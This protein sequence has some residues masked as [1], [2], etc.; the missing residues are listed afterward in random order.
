MYPEHEHII[1]EVLWAMAERLNIRLPTRFYESPDGEEMGKIIADEI[2]A[3]NNDWE[4]VYSL[5]VEDVGTW[6]AKYMQS[7][8]TANRL[9]RILRLGLMHGVIT[10]VETSD[11]LKMME[12]SSGSDVSP[13][14]KHLP[15]SS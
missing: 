10:G 9:F 6:R 2:Q 14:E 13:A 1:R 12:Y 15:E 11:L 3:S 8:D 4:R 5:A 7:R